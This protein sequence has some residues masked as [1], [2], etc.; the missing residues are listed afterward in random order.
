MPGNMSCGFGVFVVDDEQAVLRR[1]RRAGRSRQSRC[2]SRTGGAGLSA[3]LRGRIEG[4]RVG[5]ER[6]APAQQHVGVV[7]LGDVVVGRRRRPSSSVKEK[8]EAPA[9]LAL[10]A[11]SSASGLTVAEMAETASAP[12]RM[13]RREKRRGMI[14]PI[15]GLSLVL[16]GS[17]TASSSWLVRN[18][19]WAG[20]TR[21]FIVASCENLKKWFMFFRSHSKS[22]C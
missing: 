13:P 16:C 5:E 7:A 14:S 20:S 6:V 2:C 1:T 22:L 15:V 19:V 4:R 21:S 8:A 12:F 3:R 10:S 18:W 11:A 17:P 9:A